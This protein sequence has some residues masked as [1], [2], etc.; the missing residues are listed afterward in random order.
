M[1]YWSQRCFLGTVNE[2]GFW[3]FSN[4]LVLLPAS[5]SDHSLYLK[6]NFGKILCESVRINNNNK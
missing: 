3:T 6:L 1:G 2:L 5:L 4:A